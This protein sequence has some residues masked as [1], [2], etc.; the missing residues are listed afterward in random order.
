MANK[1]EPSKKYLYIYLSIVTLFA[2]ITLV[3]YYY[4]FYLYFART[5]DNVDKTAYNI[6]KV[7]KSICSVVVVNPQILSQ[8]AANRCR[9]V[10]INPYS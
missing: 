2:I 9:E 3:V 10:L 8:N 5:A 1:G 7:I 4:Y 6:N